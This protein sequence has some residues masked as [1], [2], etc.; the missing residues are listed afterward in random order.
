VRGL[1]RKSSR[2]SSGSAGGAAE[3]NKLMH[4]EEPS[5]PLNI[6][7][8]RTAD[9]PEVNIEETLQVMHEH[10]CGVNMQFL[11][12]CIIMLLYLFSAHGSGRPLW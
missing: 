6:T 7:R 2:S 12:F 3:L 5:Q 8:P 9:A 4:L 10:A 11:S 1:P